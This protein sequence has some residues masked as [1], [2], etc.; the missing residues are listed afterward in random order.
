MYRRNFN[1]INVSSTLLYR[2]K[3]NRRISSVVTHTLSV[4]EVWG[5][6]PGPVKL[7]TVRRFF[8]AVLPRRKAAEMEPTTG[9]TLRRNTASIMKVCLF[10]FYFLVCNKDRMEDKAAL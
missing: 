7:D 10:L 4:R 8:G 9:F 2:P 5:S 3:V 1:F 6:I